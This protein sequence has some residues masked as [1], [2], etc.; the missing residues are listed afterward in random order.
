MQLLSHVF[1]A[2]TGNAQSAEAFAMYG[3]IHKTAFGYH[4][5]QKVLSLISV[6]SLNNMSGLCSGCLS[7]TS[8][9]DS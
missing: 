3:E 9:I 2:T 4:C 1:P 8:L 6:L 5:C 7:K